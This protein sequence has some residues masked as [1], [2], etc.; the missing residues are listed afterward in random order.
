MT[1][2]DLSTEKAQPV[3]AFKR[4]E[5]AERRRKLRVLKRT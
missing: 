1:N 5:V 3:E 4:F 2:T